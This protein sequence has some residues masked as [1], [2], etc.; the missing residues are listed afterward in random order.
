MFILIC[1]EGK[2]KL[3]LLNRW[4]WGIYYLS[5]S[6]SQLFLFEGSSKYFF[7]LILCYFPFY[8]SILLQ[9]NNEA[10]GITII[11]LKKEKKVWSTSKHPKIIILRRL[12]ST[13]ES[14]DIL[15]QSILV[16]NN[17]FKYEIVSEFY[18][19]SFKT[20]FKNPGY[21]ILG[22]NDLYTKWKVTW[23]FLRST[24]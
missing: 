21:T 12:A 17:I 2:S 16:K 8:Q 14:K 20:G 11:I 24:I 9:K 5:R 1:M 15:L 19:S 6:L 13:R 23:K 10:E 7:F 22:W 4:I 3:P 18:N